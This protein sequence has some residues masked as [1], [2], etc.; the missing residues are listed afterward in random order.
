MPVISQLE[1]GRAQVMDELARRS[2]EALASAV[3]LSPRDAADLLM[4]ATSFAG[5]D[6]LVTDRQRS[7]GTATELYHRLASRAVT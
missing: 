5:W 7:P 2:D 1:A 4:A 6:H 3:G